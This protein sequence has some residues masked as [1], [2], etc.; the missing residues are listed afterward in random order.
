M[1][2]TKALVAE[3]PED[4]KNVLNEKEKYDEV[5]QGFKKSSKLYI[6]KSIN[7]EV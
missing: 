7:I 2:A 1:E 6:A 4:L 3:L 5:A